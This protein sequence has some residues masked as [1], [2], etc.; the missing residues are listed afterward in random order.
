[1]GID[2]PGQEGDVAEVNVGGRAH[3]RVIG[4]EPADDTT[5]DKHGGGLVA[6]WQRDAG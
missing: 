5:G 2:E 1:M 3:R 4:Q 6:T